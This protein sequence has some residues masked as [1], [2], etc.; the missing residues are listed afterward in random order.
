MKLHFC[1]FYFFFMCSGQSLEFETMSGYFAFFE[2]RKEFGDIYG[3]AWI[4][5]GFFPFSD[6]MKRSFK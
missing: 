3:L 2:P 1:V 6:E 4:L 5:N